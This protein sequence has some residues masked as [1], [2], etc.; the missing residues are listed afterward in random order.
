MKSIMSIKLDP[1]EKPADQYYGVLILPETK[2]STLF[3]SLIHKIS[4]IASMLWGALTLAIIANVSLRYGFNASS[5]ILEELQWHLYA[6]GLI[7]AIGYAHSLDIH[8]RVDILVPRY[9]LKAQAWIEM[10]GLLLLFAPY[11]GLMLFYSVPFI[12]SSFVSSEVGSSPGGIPWRWFIKSFL[13]IG[14]L[15]L[16]LSGVARFSQCYSYLFQTDKKL[17]G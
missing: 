1:K 12:E 15:L 10:I 14:F 4:I 8:V 17:K 16:A 7:I 13:P 6:V 2:I 9:S 3:Y 5:I 11:V